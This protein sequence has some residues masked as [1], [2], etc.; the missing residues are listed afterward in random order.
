M[1]NNFE[2]LNAFF[3]WKLVD[4]VTVPGEKCVVLLVKLPYGLQIKS[5]SYP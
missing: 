2:E 4:R 3:I 1:R 5:L